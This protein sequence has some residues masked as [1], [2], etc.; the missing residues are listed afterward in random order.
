MHAEQRIAKRAMAS[1][2]Q[3]GDDACFIVT[4]TPSEVHAALEAAE[5]AGDTFALLTLGNTSEW[6]GKPLYIR[7]SS[8]VAIS[9]P[10][11]GEDDA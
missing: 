8:V 7:P 1:V 2:Y 3:H 11:T 5:Q 4:Q 6:N 10:K 9:P